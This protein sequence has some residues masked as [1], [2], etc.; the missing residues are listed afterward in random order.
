MVEWNKESLCRVLNRIN[1][2]HEWTYSETPSKA[3]FYEIDSFT[4]Y[5]D[6]TTIIEWLAYEG[7]YFNNTD[8]I[9]NEEALTLLH[10][11]DKN[12]NPHFAED[13]TINFLERGDKVD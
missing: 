11:L 2:D 13:K 9:T 7:Y 8:E 5:K 10:W 4:I 6:G 1:H 3:D 12:D